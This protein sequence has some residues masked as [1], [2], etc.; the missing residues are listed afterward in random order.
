VRTTILLAAALSAVAASAADIK[1]F[2]VKMG[3]WE[4]TSTSEVAGAPAMPAIPKEKLDQL[5]PEQR[6]RIDAMLKGRNAQSTSTRSCLTRE[7]LSRAL[8][9]SHDDACKTTLV[10]STSSKQEIHMECARDTAKS[11]GDIT[12]ERIDAEHAKGT[13]V[14][15]STMQG[16]RSMSMKLSFTSKWI[17]SDCGDVKPLGEK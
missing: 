14:V 11:T 7:S 8:N 17:S 16:G 3:L 1:P 10:S 2:D 6:A 4:T 15:Q 13:G 9:F 12:I 5:P